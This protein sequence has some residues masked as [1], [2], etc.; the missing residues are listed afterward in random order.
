MCTF[1]ISTG[2]CRPRIHDAVGVDCTPGAVGF[3]KLCYF[4]TEARLG[5]D[6]DNLIVTSR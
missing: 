3:A 1:R 4:P 5:L 2:V 6:N